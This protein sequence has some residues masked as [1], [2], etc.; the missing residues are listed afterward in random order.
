[1]T[2]KKIT[3][4]TETDASDKDLKEAFLKCGLNDIRYVR[5]EEVK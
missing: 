2:T 4:I 3:I 5:V 1:M